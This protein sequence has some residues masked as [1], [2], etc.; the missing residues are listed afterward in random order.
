MAQRGSL[1]WLWQAF[2]GLLLVILLTLHMIANHFMANGLLT[3]EGIIQHLSNPVVLVLEILFLT[4]VIF[5]AM[6][7]I[8]ALI[9]DWG[10]SKSVDNTVTRVLVVIGVLMLA[11]GVWL[12][13]VIL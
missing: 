5:H 12:F 11:Y 3:Y 8:R 10:V 6:S 13:T 2:T 4:S 1:A 7:G 9:L